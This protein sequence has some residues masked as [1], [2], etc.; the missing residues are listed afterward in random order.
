MPRFGIR[1]I[2]TDPVVTALLAV[3]QRE[4]RA[5]AE[6]FEQLAE[7]PVGLATHLTIDWEGHLIYGVRYGRFEIAYHV[8]SE[9][10]VMMVTTVRPYR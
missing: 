6:G 7:D 8:Q 1:Y 10:G 3:S 5:L 9:T 2:I 4:Q